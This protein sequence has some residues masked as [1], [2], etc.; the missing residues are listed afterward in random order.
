MTYGQPVLGDMGGPDLPPV[1]LESARDVGEMQAQVPRSRAVAQ[2]LRQE[3]RRALPASSPRR[4]SALLMLSGGL[5]SVALLANILE[6]TDH[7]LHAH[8]IEI[9]NYENRK[10]AENQAVQA[11]LAY[12][13]ERYRAFSYSTSRS[14]F[15]L[16]RGGGFDLTLVLFTASRVHTAL[17]RV[18]DIVYT[19]HI[20]PTRPEILEGS[21]VFNACYINKRFKPVWLRPLARLKKIDIYDS[22]PQELADLTW[23][24]RRPVHTGSGYEPCGECHTCRSMN[25]INRLRRAQ[26]RA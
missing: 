22:I 23:S 26:A 15:P 20:A 16:G 21:A 18:I 24:C 5:D 4:Y 11:V 12:C 9:Q 10:Q 8:H 3:I 1:E 7:S 13:R 17:G 2:A 14:E 19:G 25:E 6:E